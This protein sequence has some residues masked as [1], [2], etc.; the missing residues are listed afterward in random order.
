MN[1]IQPALDPGSSV[2]SDWLQDAVDLVQRVNARLKPPPAAGPGPAT[3]PGRQVL[4]DDRCLEL[5]ALVP[6]SI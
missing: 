1:T 3:R 4:T 6:G 2:F 5:A